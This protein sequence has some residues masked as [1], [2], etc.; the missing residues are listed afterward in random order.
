M[1]AVSRGS[2]TLFDQTFIG[3]QNYRF[4][5]TLQ[6]QTGDILTFDTHDGM[7]LVAP[8]SLKGSNSRKFVYVVTKNLHL[9]LAGANSQP[10]ITAPATVTIKKGSTFDPLADVTATDADDGTITLTAANVAGTVDVNTLGIYSITYTVT[11]SD[12]AISEPVTT[13]VT[14][15]AVKRLKLQSIMLLTIKTRLKL[16]AKP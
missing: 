9:R 11:D 16:P 3:D 4:K 5:Q 13:I 14:I 12:G 6:L 7:Q 1:P 8:E 10:I 2:E 15:E